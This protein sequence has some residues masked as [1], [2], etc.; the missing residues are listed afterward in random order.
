MDF[1][2]LFW[3][4]ANFVV[5]ALIIGPGLALLSHVIWRKTPSSHS[6]R[7]QA[8]INFVVCLAILVIGLLV[9]G[10][11]G[12]IVTYAA[13]VLACAASQACLL[14]RGRR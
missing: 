7:A 4:L 5:P 8:A 6:L 9:A 1:A 3:H 13:L 10:R 14:G 12:R 2:D 11:D